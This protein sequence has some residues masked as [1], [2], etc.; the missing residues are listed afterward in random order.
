MKRSG[1]PRRTQP[2][3]R[4]GGLSRSE[5]L[6]RA[7]G[8]ERKA[9]S[10][11]L[12]RTRREPDVDWERFCAGAPRRCESCRF[13]EYLLRR[14]GGKLDPHH[15]LEKQFVRKEGGDVSDPRNRLML[16]RLCHAGQTS[17]LRK[18]PLTKLRDENISFASRLLGPARAAAYLCRA[19]AG[20]D[21]RV[22]KLALR[23]GE[24][25]R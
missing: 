20:E 1:P 8:P 12:R 5:G 6:A 10:S 21:P 13:P 23:A 4:T 11:T 22:D 24:E 18:V 9:S 17:R 2:L 14:T 15:V 19:Y 16:C 7:A 3:R 25:K